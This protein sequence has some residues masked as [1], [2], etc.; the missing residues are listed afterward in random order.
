LQK[1]TNKI[2]NFMPIKRRT[3]PWL[4]CDHAIQ[5]L[6]P[7]GVGEH[8]NVRS[9]RADT[10]VRADKKLQDDGTLASGRMM[11]ALPYNA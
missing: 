10:Q 5:A 8:L 1:L 9:K 3:N 4:S 7:A 6:R 2:V 11:T